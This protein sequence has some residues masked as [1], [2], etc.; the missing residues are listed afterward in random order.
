MRI[1]VA[2]GDG[3][4]GWA[5]SLRLASS[6]YEVLIL[7]NF[8]RRKI[9]VDLGTASLNPIYDLD[10]RISTAEKKIGKISFIN[11]DLSSQYQKLV[12]IM[13]AFKPD[14]IVHFAEQRAAPYSMVAARERRYTIGNNVGSTHNICSA[15]V[16]VDKN[17]HIVHLGTMGVY[18]Y[19]D[20][21]GAIPEGYLDITIDGTGAKD[22]IV[23]PP[24]PG[25][26]YHLSKV[27][28]HQICNKT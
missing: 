8:S 24:S 7:D 4:C 10:K 16:D 15:I 6:G 9:D 27:L 3:F 21:Y 11:I 20:K 1:I 28:D 26:I 17:I 25:S 14:A 19:D 18:G 22:S 5:S 23:Y 2:G 13:L 12:E